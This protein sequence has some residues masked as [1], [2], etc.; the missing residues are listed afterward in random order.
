M[1]ATHK[2]KFSPK[3]RVHAVAADDVETEVEVDSVKQHQE[4]ESDVK[5]GSVLRGRFLLVCHCHV[6]L[7]L[8]LMKCS[9]HNNLV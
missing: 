3:R 5:H 8:S 1:Q 4:A 6:K 7:M 9:S 2:L